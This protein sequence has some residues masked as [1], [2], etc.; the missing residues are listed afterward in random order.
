[1]HGTAVGTGGHSSA[2]GLVH[3]PGE[4]WQGVS[5]R[6][7]WGSAEPAAALRGDLR[8]GWLAGCQSG[9]EAEAHPQYDAAMQMAVSGELVQCTITS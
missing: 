8:Y 3:I 7:L 6:R 2:H 1:M 5:S 4:G 9:D